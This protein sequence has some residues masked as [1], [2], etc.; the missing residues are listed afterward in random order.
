MTDSKSLI[1]G[2]GTLDVDLKKLSRYA[3]IELVMEHR[4]AGISKFTAKGFRKCREEDFE[5][6]GIQMS[7]EFRKL[8]K[9][10]LCPDTDNGFIENYKVRNSYTNP[11]DRNSFSISIRKCN[12]KIEK[13]CE[14]DYQ[15]N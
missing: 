2:H 15:M 4:I 9:Y 11:T 12:P 1:N 5:K 7:A 14:S 10:R 6:T 8:I 3:V 13:I